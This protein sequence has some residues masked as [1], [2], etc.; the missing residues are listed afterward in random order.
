MNKIK[1]N[2][3]KFELKKKNSLLNNIF[4]LKYIN[5]L[6]IKGKKTKAENIIYKTLYVLNSLFK[7][8][9]KFILYLTVFYNAI[10]NKIINKKNQKNQ[11]QNIP[12]FKNLNSTIK[13]TIFI[14]TFEIKKFKNSN[15]FSYDFILELLKSMLYKSSITKTYLSY[16][17]KIVNSK[18]NVNFRW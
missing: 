2:L 15:L 7:K 16:N 9:P 8:N 1:K 17:K 14:I 10:I 12:L 5:R 6:T 11:L 3:V 13:N 18:K 4:I